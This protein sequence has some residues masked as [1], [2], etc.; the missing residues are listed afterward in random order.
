MIADAMTTLITRYF[1]EV[2]NEGRVDALDDLLTPDYL[3][4]S[5]STPNPPRG[6]AG[7]KP[8]VRAMREAIPDLHYEILDLIATHDKAAVHLRV[9]GTQTGPL[10]GIP[11]TGQRID[12]RQMQ[13]EWIKDGRIWQHWRITDE[14]ALMRQLRVID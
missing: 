10:F 4:H 13:I 2:W 1:Q 8:I 11:A 9:T 7:L 5:P 3:N 14:L 6:P 12:V